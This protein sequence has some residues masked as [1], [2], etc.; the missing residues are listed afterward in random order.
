M[1]A[2]LLPVF[3]W[4]NVLPSWLFPYSPE[5]SRLGFEQ[6]LRM[7]A[8]CFRVMPL[9]EAVR[10]LESEARLPPRAAA[11]TFDDGYRDALYV[12]APMLERLGVPATF[13]L[14]PGLLS[15]DV[16]P[17]WEVAAWTFAR[18]TRSEA[19]WEGLLLDLRDHARRAQASKAV[20]ERLKFRDAA[21][22][23]AAIAQLVEALAPDGELDHDALFLDWDGARELA[24]RGGV[25]IGSHT[26]SHP[27]LSRES[28][29]MQLAELRSSR[30]EL[31][32]GLDRPVT[33]LAYPN[34]KR[35]DY[36]ANTVS[37]AREAGYAHGLTSLG[38]VNH[39]KTPPFEL[40]RITLRPDAGVLGLLR[41]FSRPARRFVRQSLMNR[42]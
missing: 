13:F 22:R 33:S 40:R 10:R 12:V 39:S 8:A 29:E 31:E 34:G 26:R 23:D 6:Q 3:C 5:P 24:A 1:A 7:L 18:A 32:Q 11:L 27:I 41:A 19:V 36:D 15:R 35:D 30:F 37:A 9:G 17:W 2:R 42:A 21:A 14:V 38:G 25:E 4:H 16:T 28:R 20:L